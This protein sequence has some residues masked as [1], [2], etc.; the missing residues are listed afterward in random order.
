MVKIDI[1]S[2]AEK[3]GIKSLSQ[4]IQKT[5]LN[6]GTASR[7]WYSDKWSMIGTSTIDAVC[8]TLSCKPQDF[9]KYEADAE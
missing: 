4:F 8:K 3:R 9:I 6:N 5:G 2:V 1:R 7:W